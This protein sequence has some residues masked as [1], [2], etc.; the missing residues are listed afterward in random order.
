M[1]I[2]TIDGKGNRATAVRVIFAVVCFAVLF[3]FSQFAAAQGTFY[4]EEKKDNKIY[5]FNNMQSYK[6]WKEGGEM[7]V[8]ITRIGAGPN[9]ET[10]VF[11]S[12][13]AIHL[14]NFKH[15]LPAE[16]LIVPEEKKPVMKVTWKD[17]KTTIDT[18]IAQLNISNRIQVR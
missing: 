8:S 16:V 11:D 17:G 4:V 1:K 9:G 3:L 12:N 14:Y 5:V 15:D 6:M 10:M 13:D 18:D 2:Q 7:G